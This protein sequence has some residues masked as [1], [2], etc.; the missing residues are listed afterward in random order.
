LLGIPF[1]LILTRWTANASVVAR[2]FVAS[3]VALA[4]WLIN[5]YAILSWLQP[6]LVENVSEENL[7]INAI[8][9]WVAAATHLVF[10]WTMVALYPLGQFT[11]HR[12]L[13]DR[14]NG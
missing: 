8:P 4:I 9:P 3:V 6:L 14:E 12:L 5:Y 1:Y 13:T 11:P 2:L 7:I 10:G